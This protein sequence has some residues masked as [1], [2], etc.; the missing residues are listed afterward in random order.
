MKK[1]VLSTANGEALG[2][3]RTKSDAYYKMYQVSREDPSA[4]FEIAERDCTAELKNFLVKVRSLQD[5]T[6]ECEHVK[7]FNVDIK[8]QDWR[9][10]MVVY[11]ALYGENYKTLL[12]KSVDESTTAAELVG[13]V[14]G[15]EEIL[16]DTD[17]GKEPVEAE[18][19]EESVEA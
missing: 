2:E 14:R 7:S 5:S 12:D 11:V 13:I 6:F 17:Y 8:R 15:I 4:E 3:Y 9:D 1:F 18:K 16:A 10:G 19:A